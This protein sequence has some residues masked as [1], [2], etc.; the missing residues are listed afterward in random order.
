MGNFKVNR[1]NLINGYTTEPLAV[2]PTA[3]A[4]GLQNVF[5]K[6][7]FELWRQDDTGTETQLTAGGTGGY[8][9]ASRAITA[10]TGLTGG[11]ALSS[12]V[13]LSLVASGVSAGSYTNTNLTVDVYGRITSATNGSAG[14]GTPGSNLLATI[15]GVNLKNV[16]QQA[17]YT[18]PSGKKVYVTR[19]IVELT[20]ITGFVTVGSISAG[21]NSGVYNDIIADTDLTGLSV[22]GRFY[23]L[24][25]DGQALVASAT[26][27]IRININTAFDA[28]TA[29]ATI[30]L[31]GTEV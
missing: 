30:V 6:D 10:G 1:P 5:M 9:P 18:V 20:T 4:T 11:G 21:R 19:I 16:G 8:V 13:T 12:D 28:S 31:I 14:S 29:T 27:S 25:V 23:V 26:D 3:P 15:T 22:V 2:A 7:D 17:L 24:D